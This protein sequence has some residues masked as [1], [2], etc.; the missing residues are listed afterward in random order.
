MSTSTPA[1]TTGPDAAAEEVE[2]GQDRARRMTVPVEVNGSGPFDFVIDTGAERTM[3]THELARDL[4]LEAETSGLVHTLSGLYTV[5]LYN[6]DELSVAGDGVIG[7]LAPGVDR[8]GLGAAGLLG[9]DSLQ[10]SR[11]L[12]DMRR[13]TMSVLPS[14]A[15]EGHAFTRR[16]VITIVADR[17]RGRMIL[18]DARLNRVPVRVVLDTGAQITVG[19]HALREALVRRAKLE[20]IELQDVLGE[21][22]AGELHK[23]RELKFGGVMMSGGAIVYSDAPIFAELGLDEEPAILLGMSML[24]AFDNVEVD[25]PNRLVAFDVPGMT[26]PY[27]GIR[28]DCQGTLI[29]TGGRC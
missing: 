27:S 16:G 24:K 25:F 14:A 11:V 1:A 23:I 28:T 3:I 17:V 4:G 10:N 19:N 15:D 18:T 7:L 13:E 21:V 5:P 12:F 22:Q 8:Q 20:G 2:L 6:V 29:R 26:D 9:L